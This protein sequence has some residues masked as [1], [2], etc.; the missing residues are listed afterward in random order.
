MGHEHSSEGRHQLNFCLKL[1]LK[2][3]KRSNHNLI[4]I[5]Q[6]INFDEFPEGASKPQE[7][8]RERVSIW[9]RLKKIWENNFTPDCLTFSN[10]DPLI[11]HIFSPILWLFL[12]QWGLGSF[13][14]IDDESINQCGVYLGR[15]DITV[16]CHH[17]TCLLG[18]LGRPSSV[19]AELVVEYMSL[20]SK[21]RDQGWV[22]GPFA[23]PLGAQ[24]GID[25][26]T[27]VEMVVW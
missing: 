9:S 12:C 15:A 14:N 5:K 13:I 25:Q 16:T 3:L 11:E 21:R 18:I 24:I 20:R 1:P 19:N 4:I 17:W 6:N 23:L 27:F 7:T 2:I 22:S 26:N 10:D 8:F